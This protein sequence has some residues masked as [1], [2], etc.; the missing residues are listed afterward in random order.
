MDYIPDMILDGILCQICGELHDDFRLP[1]D[2]PEDKEPPEKEWAGFPQTCSDCLAK[3]LAG[4]ER[5]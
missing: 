5:E 2:W 1:D 3:A 4:E